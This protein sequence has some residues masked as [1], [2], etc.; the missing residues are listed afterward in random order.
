VNEAL[1]PYQT[2]CSFKIMIHGMALMKFPSQLSQETHYVTTCCLIQWHVHTVKLFFP[3]GVF[4][5]IF[6]KK[7]VELLIKTVFCKQPL[8][9]AHSRKVCPR[10]E[11]SL[12]DE[13]MAFEK[14]MHICDLMD[15][16]A[17]MHIHREYKTWNT[18][19]HCMLG[20]WILGFNENYCELGS[21]EN[22]NLD[23]LTMDHSLGYFYYRS[24]RSRL[25]LKRVEIRRQST[26]VIG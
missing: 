15:W 14:G 19:G 7:A 24:E 1:I 25:M 3:Y 2:S 23:Y 26:L 17:T 8:E 10:L 6:N 16:H 9:D 21:S 20:D 12:A 13:S 18:P 5:T 4:G 11:E 22:V